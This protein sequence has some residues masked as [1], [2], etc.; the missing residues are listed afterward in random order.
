MDYISQIRE[1]V[2]TRQLLIPSVSAL[3]FDEDQRVLLCRKVGSQLWGLVGGAVEPGETPAEAVVREAQEETGLVV[4]PIRV[5]GVYGGPD[6]FVNYPNGD[7]VAYISTTFLCEPIGGRLEA[8]GD[9]IVEL[10]F[11][12]EQ[13]LP[14]TA[15]TTIAAVVLPGVFPFGDRAFFQ[16]P[17]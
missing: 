11:I 1:H 3:V 8:D 10:R 4:R 16:I 15:L 2:G 13:D 5:L 9:E 12:S 17:D 14:A 7:E 6:F